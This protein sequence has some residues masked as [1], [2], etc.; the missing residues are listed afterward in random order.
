MESSY[1]QL[2]NTCE[3]PSPV[4]SE[5]QLLDFSDGAPIGG[6][7]GDRVSIFTE[8]ATHL[9][10][11]GGSEA[12]S[13]HHASGGSVSPRVVEATSDSRPSADS[14]PDWRTAVVACY[15]Q[16]G[17]APLIETVTF[18][19]PA[20]YIDVVSLAVMNC[21]TD[22]NGGLT[23]EVIYEL[24]S[25]LA[26][27]DFNSPVIS[28]LD[29]G[30]TI[31]VSDAGPGIP[32]KSA[33]MRP[34]FTSATS[35][36]R[37]VIRGVGAGLPLVRSLVEPQGGFVVIDDNIGGGTVVT[38]SV[39][40]HSPNRYSP[41]AITSGPAVTAVQLAPQHSVSGPPGRP[42]GSAETS[43]DETAK[44]LAGAPPSVSLITSSSA[45]VRG[46]PLSDRQ[47]EVLA[48]VADSLEAGPSTV[49]SLLDIPLSTAYR[50][51]KFLEDRGLVS[52]LGG[53]KRQVTGMGLEL[54]R[55]Y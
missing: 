28:I 14:A 37:S 26:H 15:K 50:D 24:V 3:L 38:A 44:L 47:R 39:S 2:G 22:L 6:L 36:L 48:V 11:R 34:G 55:V 54:L 8:P 4:E 1:E 7:A 51:L 29:G 18:A 49:S 31:R 16:D 43:D 52:S 5:W 53:G 9:A 45:T 33:A 27:A 23:P 13:R 40:D 30:N 19:D 46:V 35:G 20:S 12:P 42:E 17:A 41:I 21:V 10:W 32:D 25:N